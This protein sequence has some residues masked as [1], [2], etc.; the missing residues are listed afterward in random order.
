M[1]GPSRLE[2][3]LR[4]M[5]TLCLKELAFLL[6]QKM[7]KSIGKS[8]QNIN[9]TSTS[10]C[11]TLPRRRPREAGPTGEAVHTPS[12]G[13]RHRPRIDAFDAMHQN[14]SGLYS[15][16]HQRARS[17]EHI[18]DHGQRPQSEGR[19]H[20]AHTPSAYGPNYWV[21]TGATLATAGQKRTHSA[22]RN[23][24]RGQRSAGA[25]RSLVQ[26]PQ[27]APSVENMLDESSLDTNSTSIPS[28]C[29]VD[30]RMRTQGGLSGRTSGT[31]NMN[32]HNARPKRSIQ[33]SSD[34]SSDPGF[35]E[36][37]P[38]STASQ[39]RIYKVNSFQ[40]H[41]PQVTILLQIASI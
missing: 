31:P 1:N 8:G 14:S 4:S 32:Y 29:T 11:S 21:A 40:K 6:F 20:S 24:E 41:S 22:N 38:A 39:R 30:R 18:L 23:R 12:Q 15:P 33:I 34:E 37:R 3:F 28:Y 5:K 17:L 16:N 13:Y 26:R 7:P 9:L 2:M 27:R 35:L 10:Y 19:T 36:R 25:G